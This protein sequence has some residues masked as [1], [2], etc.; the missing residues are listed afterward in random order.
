MAHRPEGSPSLANKAAG[1]RS[2][3][4]VFGGAKNK[5]IGGRSSPGK[6]FNRRETGAPT[7]SVFK[8]SGL[9]AILR[10][11]SGG[12]TKEQLK[13]TSSSPTGVN[14][15]PQEGGTLSGTSFLSNILG[16]IQ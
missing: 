8:G 14:V 11:K 5:R 3:V 7:G 4:A 10:G 9:F 1:R 12:L 2:R 13:L 16:Q 15:G 6:A